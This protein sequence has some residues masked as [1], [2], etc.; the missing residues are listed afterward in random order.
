MEKKMNV[1]GIQVDDYTAKEAMR[2]AIDY[3]ETEAMNVIELLTTDI[4]V[5]SSVEEGVKQNIEEADMVLIGDRA[6]LEAAG[7]EEPKRLAEAEQDVFLRMFLRYLDKNRK[8][9][10]LM[11]DSEEE[12]EAFEHFLKENYPQAKLLG[13]SVVPGSAE[14]DDMIVN[15][16][17]GLEIDCI[18]SELNMSEQEAFIARNRIIVNANVWLRLGKQMRLAG[19]ESGLKLSVRNFFQKSILKKEIERENRKKES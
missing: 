4:L 12:L 5:K 7:I 13:G 3:I 6:I 14:A 2:Q 15:E 10:Y 16:I 9:I 17:N 11:A 1:L 8:R 18:L 19:K